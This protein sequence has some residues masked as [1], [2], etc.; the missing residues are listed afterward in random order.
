MPLEHNPIYQW[1]KW[2]FI[3]AAPLL[4]QAVC[5]TGCGFPTANQGTPAAQTYSAPIQDVHPVTA[6]GGSTATA[7]SGLTTID[8]L[9]LSAAGCLAVCFLVIAFLAVRTYRHKNGTPK[10][11]P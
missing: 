4:S 2:T 3:L 8:V 10:P 11:P 5:S 9:T 7:S 6:T 1:L